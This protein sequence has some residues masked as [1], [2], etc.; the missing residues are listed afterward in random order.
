MAR[1]P[2]NSLDHMDAN[3]SAFVQRAL[4]Q[5]ET[6]VYN[7]EFPP[8]QGMQYIPVDDSFDE[9]ALTTTYRQYTR[10][11]QAKWVTGR[12][13][14]LPNVALLVKEFG[15]TFKK[16]G[17]SYRY[18]LDDIL[19]F[20]YAG[21]NGQPSVN[22]DM[23]LATAARETIER[24]LDKSCALGS[25]TSSTVPGL[26]VVAG[27]EVGG[28]LGLLNQ[29]NTT[30]YTVATGA[31]VSQAWGLK[32][33]DEILADLH[34][35]FIAIIAGTYQTFEANTLLLPISKFQ[36]IVSTR[37]GDGSD[38]SILGLF[39]KQRPGIKV[40]PWQY[41]EKAGTGGVDR[42]VAFNQ[43]KRFVKLA[44][45]S[46][47]KQYPPEYRNREFKIDCTAKTAGI[48]SPYPSTIAYGDGI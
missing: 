36:L 39:Q 2:S 33:P 43:N 41:C 32:T 22:I 26:D 35:I 28:L 11:G 24:A 6:E 20:Q 4:N 40:A 23:E 1:L 48:W 34:G 42:M 3:E 25:V 16:L 45:S 13:K 44:L 19:A 21:K 14:D 29:A 46:R 18:S 9:G 15:H 38:E 12:G 31:A 7:T 10:V 27:G 37:M 8:K 47:F 5:V 30:S 17:A